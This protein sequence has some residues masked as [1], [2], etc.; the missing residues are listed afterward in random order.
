MKKAK[1]KFDGKNNLFELGRK[2]TFCITP[3]GRNDGYGLLNR[4]EEEKH[5]SSYDIVADAYFIKKE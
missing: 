3:K 4:E 5:A 2:E 1:K